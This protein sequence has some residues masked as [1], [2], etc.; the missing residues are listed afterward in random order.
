[1]T[2]QGTIHHIGHIETV[3]A[4]GFT[5]Q[6][7]VVNNGQQYDNLTPIEFVKDKT[8]LLSGLSVGQSVTVHINLGGREYNSKFY[9][10]VRGWKVEADQSAPPQ[11]LS[12]PPAKRSAPV[13]DPA[14]E[15]TLPF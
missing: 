9:P 8:G 14:G 3:G 13:A 15:D 5:K 11:P 6:L 1:M 2:V 7:L 10:S 4:N 12:A